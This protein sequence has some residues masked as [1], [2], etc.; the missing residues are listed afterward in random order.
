MIY[1]ELIQCK[2]CGEFKAHEEYYWKD[3]KL[4]QYK[5]KSCH[6]KR[7][8]YKVI[9]KVCNKEFETNRPNQ[10]FCSRKCKYNFYNLFTGNSK[11]K[12]TKNKGYCNIYIL[13]CNNCGKLF[14][15]R[16]G[17]QKYCSRKCDIKYQSN[18]NTDRYI[19][20]LLRAHNGLKNEDTLILKKKKFLS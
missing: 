13:N 2:K 1:P 11:T 6:T 20:S 17:H 19:K 4:W 10:K 12:E 7:I 5:C 16:E 14:V 3:K 8:I 15:S 9:C 18:N